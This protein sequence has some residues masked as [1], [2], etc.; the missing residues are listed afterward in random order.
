M[1]QLSTM[2]V[3]SVIIGRLLSGRL[4]RA[5][6]GTSPSLRPIA[7]RTTTTATSGALF[8]QSQNNNPAKSMKRVYFDMDN[9]L[10]DFASSIVKLL[11]GQQF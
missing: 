3:P 9:V 7:A 1:V 6:R 10:V 11:T 5:A 4:A 2:Q 8:V